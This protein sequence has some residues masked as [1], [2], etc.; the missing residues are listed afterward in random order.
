MTSVASS[1]C[2]R[3]SSGVRFSIIRTLY[4]S[5]RSRLARRAPVRPPP[6]MRT[7]MSA[8]ALLAQA[9]VE[10]TNAFECRA[11]M[12]YVAPFQ[13]DARVRQIRAAGTGQRDRI[14]LHRRIEQLAERVA[15]P[16]IGDDQLVYLHFAIA[17]GVDGLLRRI[18]Q[19]FL[20]ALCAPV[21]G[22]D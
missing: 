10:Y 14:Q 22:A 8:L 21:G 11:H 12:D 17:G 7:N 6:Q 16:G 15:R 2:R 3:A 19:Q 5:L 13:D 1:W 4:P 9:C 18:G 20:D